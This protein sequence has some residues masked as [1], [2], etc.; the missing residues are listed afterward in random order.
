[1]SRV[2][3]VGMGVPSF[4]PAPRHAGPGLRSAHFA[5][6]L[7]AA[8]HDVLLLAVLEENEAAPFRWNASRLPPASMLPTASPLPPVEFTTERELA[9]P[10][11]RTRIARFAPDCVVGV[12][13]YGAALA[14]RLKLDVPMWA[15]VFGDIMAEAQAKALRSGSDWSLVHFWTLLRTVLESADRFSAVS[16]AQSHALV[17]QLGLAGRLSARTAGEELVSVVPCATPPA[18]VADRAASRRRFDLGDEAFVLLASGGVNT[19]VDVDTLGRGLALAMER[20][21]RLHLLVTGGAIPG[22]DESSQAALMSWIAR[23]PASRV[24]VLGWVDSELLPFVYAASDL[25][26]HV[27]RGLYER[28]LGSENRAVE[29]L[30]HGLVCVTTA[31]SESGAALVE[32]GFALAA[33]PGDADDLARVVGDAARALP[34]GVATARIDGARWVARERSLAAT[35]APLLEWCAEP[36]FA[37]DRDGARLLRLG[38]LSQP[39]TSA[40]MLEAYVAELPVREILRRGLRW[41]ARRS[42]AALGRGLQAIGRMPTLRGGRRKPAAR[43]LPDLAVLL[44]IAAT[45]AGGCAKADRP[46]VLLVSIDT[47]RRDHVGAYGYAAAPSPTPTLDALAKKSLVFENAVTSAPETAPALASI[48]TGVYQD[49]HGVLFNKEKLGPD[50][51]TLAE[52][53]KEAGYSTTAFIGNWLADEKH[54]FAQGFDRFEVV[55]GGPGQIDEK[56][57]SLFGDFLGTP[58][59]KGP[60][61]AWVHMMEP[62]GPYDSAPASWSADIDYSAA[63]PLNPDRVVPVSPTNFGLGVIPLYQRIEGLTRLSEYVRR[64][65]GDVKLTDSHLGSILSMLAKAGQQDR[66]VVLVVADHGESLTE[67]NEL[68]Q[69]GWFVYDPTI[70]IPLVVSWPA[71]FQAARVRNQVCAVDI[72]PSLLDLAGVEAD[73]ADFDGRSFVSALGVRPSVSAMPDSTLRDAG[74]YS[75]GPRANH[76]FSLRS[77]TRKLIVTPDGTPRDPRAPKGT[78]T[79]QPE[80]LELYDIVADPGEMTDLS[81]RYTRSLEDLQSPLAA[82]RSRFR[83]HGW[84][85]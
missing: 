53:L 27:E 38:L 33:L 75:I 42:G 80:R 10:A 67:H 22:H 36:A 1:M 3:L 79:N 18:A 46:N 5:T 82:M 7:I 2:L 14:A 35:A 54:G 8:G 24:R 56:L 12:T 52:R 85:W 19:W 45:L 59:A 32:S 55:N 81:E 66:T 6:A 25:A 39:G 73:G 16:Q 69:H 17:G 77:D 26:L 65:D 58:S 49:R 50:N 64:Y 11:M 83:A 23:L 44:A 9:S 74:C 48:V 60:W 30:A 37:R 78:T 15:D 34:E 72:L 31:R 61:L 76:V 47:L 4:V 40:E 43:R 70:R 71:R 62:H 28:R 51:R 21:A 57:V 84:R 41:I 13:V 29:W 63:A 20:D 68:L